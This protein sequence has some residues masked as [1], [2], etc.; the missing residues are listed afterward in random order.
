MLLNGDSPINLNNSFDYWSSTSVCYLKSWSSSDHLDYTSYS[1]QEFASNATKN[2]T[3]IFNESSFVGLN[4]KT[5]YELSLIVCSGENMLNQ[6]FAPDIEFSTN[7]G[8]VVSKRR[9][10]GE[11]KLRPVRRI[12]IVIGCANENILSLLQPPYF[13]SCQSCPGNCSPSL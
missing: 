2:S 13:S 6:K 7:A 11:A 3:F 12:P 1:L 9:S 5:A 4:S 10:D 8:L